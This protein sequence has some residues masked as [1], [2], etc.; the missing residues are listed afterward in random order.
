VFFFFTK[1]SFRSEETILGLVMIVLI[2]VFR[3]MYDFYRSGGL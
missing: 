1:F 3:V 2:L